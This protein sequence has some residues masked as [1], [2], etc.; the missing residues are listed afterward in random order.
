MLL[1]I[2]GL[3]EK[4]KEKEKEVSPKKAQRISKIE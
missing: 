2:L 4:E 1:E 3:K